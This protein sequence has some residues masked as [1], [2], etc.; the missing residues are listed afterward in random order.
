M[1]LNERQKEAVEYLDGPLL[2]LAGPGTGKTQLLSAK[3]AY[4]LENTDTNPEN[5]LCLTFTENGATNMRVRLNSMIGQTANK[6]NIHT[7]HAFGSNILAQYKNYAEN[8]NR[9]LDDTADEVTQFKIVKNLQAKLPALDILKNDDPKN[10]ID[11]IKSAKSARLT[12]QNLTKIA[13]ANAEESAVLSSEITPILKQLI[14]KM[15]FDQ[16][17]AKIYQPILEVLG[18][19]LGKKPIVGNIE[20]LANP[21]YRELLQILK[22]ES[23]KEKPSISPL[24]K[25]KNANFELDNSG[26]YRLKS[27]IANKKLASVANI[28]Q[29][30]NEYLEAHGL[31]DYADM[32]EEAIKIL[33]NDQGFRL[34]LSEHYQY[35]LLDEFQDT[36]PSQFELIQLITD[37]EKP[38]IMAVGDD[39]QAIFEFQGANASNLNDFKIHYDAKVVSLIDSYRS[40]TEILDF[41]YKISSQIENSFAKKNSVNKKLNSIR[42]DQGS[43]IS[44]HEFLS[45]DAEYY[46]VAAEIEKLIKGGI[47]QNDIA[48]IAP[49]HKYIASLLPYLKDHKNI[50]ISYEKSENIFEDQRIHELIILSRFVYEI[51][52]SHSPSHRLLE[53][54]SFPFWGI[55]PLTAIKAIESARGD[56]KSALEYLMKSEEKE[57]QNI[58]NF[59]AGL[60]AKSFDTPL[61]LFIDFMI[62]A[63]EPGEFRSPY[64]NFYAKDSSSYA[65]FEL[66]EN[67]TILRDTVKNHTKENR[68]T[69]K[70]LISFL[71]DYEEA[72]A[73]LNNTSP[74]QDS[75]NAI[76]I[77]SAHKSKGLEFEY[78]FLISADNNSWG[79]A[80]GNNNTLTLPKNLLQIRHTGIT[81][82]ERLRLFFVAITRAKTYLLISNS[83]QDFSGKTP[84]RLEYL[85]EYL[86]NKNQVISPYLPEASQKVICHYEDFDEAKQK[87]DLRKSWIATYKKLTPELRPILEKRLENY[88]LSATDLTSFI[89]IVYAGPMEFYKNRILKAPQEPA[90]EKI[91]FGTLMH[92]ALEKVTNKKLSDEEAVKVFCEEAEKSALSQEQIDQLIEKGTVS[93]AKTLGKFGEELRS[94][95]AKA[96]VGFGHEKIIVNDVPITGKID[97]LKINPAEKTIEIYDFKTGNYHQEKWSSNL[98]LYKYALQL[99]FYKLLLNNS[100]EYSKYKVTKAHILFIKPDIEGEINDKIYEFDKKEEKKL[101]DLIKSVYNHIKTL[102]FMDDPNLSINRDESRKLTD[103]KKFIEL[104]LAAKQ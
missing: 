54:L 31:Y 17:V 39:D 61:E 26:K 63:N 104:M 103:I 18:K 22:E 52:N 51:A 35:V 89:D 100:P 68:P 37:Y 83:I 85:G 75:K 27:H 48:I 94:N 10:I 73:T 38:A 15:P 87:T 12:A 56:K 14:P 93:L 32:V 71:D 70:D 5:I 25:W 45:A 42:G 88:R 8:Y 77:L 53:I 69:L 16:A 99:G 58:A 67:L 2:V 49:K 97:H 24:T 78:V 79:K 72:G 81:D 50:N 76:Q 41:S 47:P 74:Y 30:Y 59:L 28:M 36:N 21:L 40:T 34:T 44:R 101:L 57:L 4:I 95:T 86:D 60:A 46:W 102:D 91:I 7:Y 6:I 92:N 23:A 19:H 82:D 65:T 20:P 84:D 90:D 98:T 96:E 43:N 62:G 11:T 55:S 80:K 64:L 33:Q 29:G 13:V 66:Y 3:A 1:P 9:R